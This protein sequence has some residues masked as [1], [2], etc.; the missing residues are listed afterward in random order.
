MIPPFDGIYAQWDYN[1]GKI[2]RYYNPWVPDGVVVD[3]KNDEVFGNTH[4]ACR[5]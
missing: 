5:H 1:A 2:T 3:G 4:D